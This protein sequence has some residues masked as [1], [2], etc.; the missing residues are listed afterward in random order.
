[1]RGSVKRMARLIDSVMDFARGRLGGGLTIHAVANAP[2]QA[3]LVQVIGELRTAW[4][5]RVI[6]ADLSITQPVTCDA[7]RLGQLVSNLISN[8]LAHGAPDRPIKVSASTDATTLELAV[9]NAGAPIPPETINRL[10]QPFFR[11]GDHGD[12][13]LG[14]GLYIVAEIARAHGGT[15][16]VSSSAEETRFAARLPRTG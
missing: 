11:L 8:A 13:G 14:L 9:S 10:F 6:E 4:P 15:L 2:L 7:D 1:M 5:D 12:K 3:T 16:K